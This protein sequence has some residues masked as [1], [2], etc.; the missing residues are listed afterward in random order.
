MQRSHMPTYTLSHTHLLF[1]L[2][3]QS[4]QTMGAKTQGRRDSWT[5]RSEALV[6]RE[7]GSISLL[8]PADVKSYT[9]GLLQNSIDHIKL[10]R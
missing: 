3:L 2:L 8:K 6:H 5:S 7:S 4:K 9:S 1:L 10:L